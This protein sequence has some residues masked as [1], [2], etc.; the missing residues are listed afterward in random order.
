MQ[1]VAARRR[2]EERGARLLAAECPFSPVISAR[3]RELKREGS[4]SARLYSPAWVRERYKEERKCVFS[5]GMR[6]QLRSRA[7][8]R[9]AAPYDTA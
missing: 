9:G 8:R 3:S 7:T 1:A 2:T 4:A 6:R 5:R